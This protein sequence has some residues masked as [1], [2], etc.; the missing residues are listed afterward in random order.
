MLRDEGIDINSN[1]ALATALYYGLY[2]D[3][4]SFTEISH[5]LDRDLRDMAKFDKNLVNRLRNANMSLE[6]LEIAG[7]ALLRS[8]FIED[9]RFA[10][11]KAGECDP[12]Q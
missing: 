8:D 6:E 3:T 12:N 1:E 7:T 2:A 9:Q 10:I 5:P 4:N 11:V